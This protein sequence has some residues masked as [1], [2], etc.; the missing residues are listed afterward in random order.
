MTTYYDA[1]IDW[2][3]IRGKE[4]DWSV[5]YVPNIKDR[6][7]V[8][9]SG[10]TILF[11]FDLGQHDLPELKEL[12]LSAGLQSKLAPY[13]GA[14]GADA[15]MA[16]QRRLEGAL[17]SLIAINNAQTGAR[18]SSV[19]SMRTIGVV[20]RPNAPVKP[21]QTPRQFVAPETTVLRLELSPAERLELT[22]AIQRHFYERL[23]THYDAHRQG[24]SFAE[25]PVGIQTAL[26]SLSWQMG[27]IWSIKHPAHSLFKE[28]LQEDWTAV[29]TAL[30]QGPL[31][32]H[33][34]RA[35]AARRGAEGGLIET[36]IRPSTPMPHKRY[37]T[38]VP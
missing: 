22:N 18:T 10:A 9:K 32:K 25:L 30:R 15:V 12:H 23:R 6:R 24:R 28:A 36:A 31:V 33:V 38:A 21:G 27:N 13:L 11:G 29:V 3:F 17:D 37:Q 19:G 5:G 20:N 35:D 7:G 16:P 34:S 14:K 2:N 26:L 1:R 8:I 4:G